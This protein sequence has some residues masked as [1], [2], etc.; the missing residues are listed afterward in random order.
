MS[1]IRDH[2]I[3]VSRDGSTV[4]SGV[5]ASIQM[6]RMTRLNDRGGVTTRGDE[7]FI[8]PPKSFAGPV[9]I[10]DIITDDIGRTFRVVGAYPT[11]LGWQLK[12]SWSQGTYKT[13]YLRTYSGRTITAFNSTAATPS[14]FLLDPQPVVQTLRTEEVFGSNGVYQSGDRELVI[15]SSAVTADQVNAATEVVYG[16]QSDG[17]TPDELLHIITRAPIEVMGQVASWR[18]I[19]GI[20]K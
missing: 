4:F 3:S 6:E 12:A 20:R 19:A 1:I 7:Y 13:V 10:N 17:V 16:Y 14:D 2:T 5:A 15:A 8:F 9:E 11:L 18:V